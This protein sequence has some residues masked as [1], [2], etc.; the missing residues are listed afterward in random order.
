MINCKTSIRDDNTIDV[1]CHND[2]DKKSLTINIYDIDSNLKLVDFKFDIVTDIKIWST[3]SYNFSNFKHVNGYRILVVNNDTKER[4]YDD[5][6]LIRSYTKTKFI[7]KDDIL[8]HGIIEA[9]NNNFIESFKTFEGDTLDIKNDKVLVDLGST[10]GVFTAYALEQNPNLKSICVEMNPKF[11][12][13][14][15]DT[16]KDNPNITPIN[17]AIYKVSGATINL[18]SISED[19]Y[20][21]GNTIV[22]NLFSDQIHTLSVD[23]I[24][25]EDIIRIHNIER[26][27]LLKVD[28]EGYEYELFENLTDD[29][30]DRIDKIFIE[31]HQV[32]D[33]N[34]R[35]NLINKLMIKGFRMNMYNATINFY[36]T[37]MFSLFFTKNK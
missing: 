2:G 28:I 4:E 21:L 22:D 29:I 36:S 12:K 33:P 9:L 13:I 35:L 30:L 8:S 17:A 6:I 32:H 34:R 23:T 26:I 27:S 18:K 19:L 24:S 16:F 5:I 15:V 20:D 3:L 14:C 10:I 37:Q 11:H 1:Y 7:D 31:F 25:L